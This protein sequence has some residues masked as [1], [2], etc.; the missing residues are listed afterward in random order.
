MAKKKKS[1][2][3]E[4]NLEKQGKSTN[5]FKVESG[6]GEPSAVDNVYIPQ[7]ACGEAKKVKV[8]IEILD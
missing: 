7:W 3:V 4:M 5:K 6:G 8:T 2:I 1:F